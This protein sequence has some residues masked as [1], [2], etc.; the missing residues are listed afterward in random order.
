MSLL[1]ASGEFV[2]EFPSR[3]LEEAP[4]VVI[5]PF[6]F[7]E[8]LTNVNKVFAFYPTFILKE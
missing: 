7:T 6:G 8:L 5:H 2:S 4:G 3:T 1:P